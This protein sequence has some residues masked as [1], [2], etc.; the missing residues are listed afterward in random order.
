[1]TLAK[2]S[3]VISSE[4]KF[5]V[6]VNK[7][8]T[9]A[10]LFQFQAFTVKGGIKTR[11][12]LDFYKL[13]VNYYSSEM[14]LSEAQDA[15]L[16]ECLHGLLVAHLEGVKSVSRLLDM[17]GDWI[18]NS[19]EFL[20]P[21]RTVDST[22]VNREQRRSLIRLPKAN[23][24][25][26]EDETKILAAAESGKEKISGSAWRNKRYLNIF[27]STGEAFLGCFEEFLQVLQSEEDE[28]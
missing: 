10:D 8:H 5:R 13:A 19:H 27:M 21:F 7:M 9:L 18:H 28:R 22:S 3:S 23:L 24:D 2:K 6:I 1:M 26:V 12:F 14:D 4:D 11:R 25:I 16:H 20:L 15:E 17:F